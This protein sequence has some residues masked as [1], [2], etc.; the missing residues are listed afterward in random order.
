MEM[1]YIILI[2]E[3]SLRNLPDLFFIFFGMFATGY[4]VEGVWE[5]RSFT[6]IIILL[7]FYL[8]RLQYWETR[9]PTQALPAG[10]RRDRGS[11]LPLP[12]AAAIL[13]QPRSVGAGRAS[14]RGA[15]A[16]A[17]LWEERDDDGPSRSPLRAA[18]PAAVTT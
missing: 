4:S 6:F 18:L 7:L 12:G 1:L 8:I 17:R 16:L 2:I 3:H 13:C 10:A 11:L 14:R 9:E 15:A 5:P